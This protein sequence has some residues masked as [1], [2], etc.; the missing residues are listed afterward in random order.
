M[1][2]WQYVT[3]SVEP[4][5]TAVTVEEDGDVVD[6]DVVEAADDAADEVAFGASDVTSLIITYVSFTV[7]YQ[8]LLVFA[9]ISIAEPTDN[10]FATE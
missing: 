1:K 3:K 8:P 7:R 4:G 9:A 5:L 6:E 10:V 2:D